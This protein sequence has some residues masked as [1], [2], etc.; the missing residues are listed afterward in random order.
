MR[1]TIKYRCRPLPSEGLTTFFH[2]TRWHLDK[3]LAD[4]RPMPH[5]CVVATRY[6]GT[7]CLSF[8][9][10]DQRMTKAYYPHAPQAVNSSTM[11]HRV[12]RLP[13]LVLN[14]T[15]KPRIGRTARSTVSNM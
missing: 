1:R 2:R 10:S 14:Y 11:Q 5:H 15:T 7:S 9:L 12:C 8:P 13:D 3:G 6:D 4:P